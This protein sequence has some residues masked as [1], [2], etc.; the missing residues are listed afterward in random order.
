MP[1]MAQL[2]CLP[3]P[4]QPVPEIEVYVPP[5][6]VEQSIQLPDDAPDVRD[7]SDDKLYSDGHYLVKEIVVTPEGHAFHQ[8]PVD[9]PGAKWTEVKT[10]SHHVAPDRVTRWLIVQLRT[11]FGT[12]SSTAAS[13]GAM[14][15]YANTLMQFVVGPT[16]KQKCAAIG[17]AMYWVTLP[18]LREEW[19]WMRNKRIRAIFPPSANL[20]E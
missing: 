9:T 15:R 2:P 1:V 16:D 18:T 20:Q 11:I 17:K 13:L 5:P 10:E 14:R 19:V 8:P 6:R 12:A 7:E 3:G 4:T